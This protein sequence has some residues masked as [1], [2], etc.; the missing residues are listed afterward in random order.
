MGF[1]FD[2]KNNDYKLVSIQRLY[3]NNPFHPVRPCQQEVEV[4]S[5]KT[6]CLKLLPDIIPTSDMK[7][8]KRCSCGG[9]MFS[10]LV[11]NEEYGEHV[12]SFDIS[13]EVFVTTPLPLPCIIESH[14]CRNR[15]M[16]HNKSL[17]LDRCVKDRNNDTE[18]HNIWVLGEYG[19]K[20]SWTNIFDVGPF[21]PRTKSISGFWNNN[22]VHLQVNGGGCR[23]HLILVDPSNRKIK[24]L[25]IDGTLM[26]LF[27]YQERNK[28]LSG[29]LEEAYLDMG[30]PFV[31]SNFVKNQLCRKK[32]LVVLDDVNNSSQLDYL[33]GDHDRFGPRSRIIVTTRDKQ[34]LSYRAQAIY[35]VEKL[36]R[37]EAL[38]LFY[39][40]TQGNDSLPTNYIEM[41]NQNVLKLS[42][43]G[44]DDREKEIFLDIACFFKGDDRDYVQSILNAYGF[45][46]DI[47]IR[48]LIDKSLINIMDNKLW[49]HDL[50]QEMGK[51]I[52][53]QQSKKE[54]GN[55]SRLWNDDGTATVEAISLDMS[56]LDKYVYSS[57]VAFLKMKNLRLLKVYSSFLMDKH[58]IHFP[59]GLQFLP[60][61]LRYLHWDGYPLKAFSSNF[62]AMNLIELC[63]HKSWAKKLWSGVLNVDNLKMIDLSYSKHLTQ[64]PDLSR[65]PN[66]ES[67]DLDHCKSLVRVPYCFQNLD[68]LVFL[69]MRSCRNLKT[70]HRLEG[71]PTTLCKLKSLE[72]LYLSCCSKF[73]N[74]PEILEPM[75]QLWYLDLSRTV[76]ED[77]T[78]SIENLIRLRIGYASKP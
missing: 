26:Q 3:E 43:E 56:K 22:K 5:L 6:G 16:F 68:K 44:L 46:T 41:S 32:V 63:M 29:L 76:I 36:D 64:I 45:F 27:H 54:P 51:E 74:F 21:E 33:A 69:L 11:W 7:L 28:L 72:R 49:M 9:E 25:D 75:E 8:A 14:D 59:Q 19:V 57:P 20:E 65:A 50:L 70:L 78:S 12:I 62:I 60:D 58:K 38:E 52:I 34:L 17:A 15:L 37:D 71:F 30:T 42:Y 18:T 10:W 31:V 1:G 48:V 73:K 2:S 53:R 13:N 55:R 61:A 40:K 24:D 66:L 23:H 47:G 39:F 4:Y 67:I 35:D 77:I